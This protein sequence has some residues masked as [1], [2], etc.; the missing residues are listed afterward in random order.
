MANEQHLDS[1]QQNRNAVMAGSAPRKV[2]LASTIGTTL[3]FY[4]FIVYGT[5]AALAFDE[6]FFPAAAAGA[7]TLLALSTFAIG[8]LAR[9]AGAALFG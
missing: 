5:V 1:R 9:P 2:V 3:E 4:D 8:F 6:L 7:G